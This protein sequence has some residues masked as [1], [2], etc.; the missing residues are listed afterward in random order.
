MAKQHQYLDLF[1]PMIG[2]IKEKIRLYAVVLFG[3]RARGDAHGF[4]DHDIVVI[5]DFK[6]KY[7]QRRDWVIRLAPLVSVDM[8]CFTPGEFHKLFN[9]LDLTAIDAIGEGIV[10]CGDDYIKPYKE[11]F[12]DMTARGLKKTDCL[13]IP[14]KRSRI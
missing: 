7:H 3:S 13:I 4:S 1:S 8:F 14:P 10:L 2:A 11:K 12:E 6:E 9:D 5:A